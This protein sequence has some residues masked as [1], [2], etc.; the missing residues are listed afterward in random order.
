MIADD[1]CID[2]LEAAGVNTD[3]GTLG[4]LEITPEQLR[5]AA[6]QINALIDNGDLLDLESPLATIQILSTALVVI[7]HGARDA[8][9]LAV[10]A[11]HVLISPGVTVADL[12]AA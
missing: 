1:A 2:A 4:A 7:A 8:E 10:A 6:L 3:C 9:S 11:L 12:L 5:A